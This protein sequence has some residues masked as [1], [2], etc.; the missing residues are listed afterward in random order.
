MVMSSTPMPMP[1]TKRH[2]LRPCAVSWNA[3]TV[4]AAMYQQQR[5][6]EDRSSAKTVGEKAA[7]DRA[8]E[9]PGEERRNEARDAGRAEE[10]RR[11]GRENAAFNETGRDVAREEKIVQLEKE[12]ETEQQNQ[13]PDRARR[14][15]SVEAGGNCSD[16]GDRG[17]FGLCCVITDA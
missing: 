1:E 15:K 6:G 3:I 7:R 17:R 10:P 13:L 12:S 4:F 5:P 14:G 11:R 2:K 8:D 9:Q 16:A